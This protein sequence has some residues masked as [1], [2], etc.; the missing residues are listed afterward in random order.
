MAKALDSIIGE[1]KGEPDPWG[2]ERWQRWRAKQEQDDVTKPT[3]NA[4]A[5]ARPSPE[6]GQQESGRTASR[7]NL[8][9]G[10]RIQWP[11]S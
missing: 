10:G 7:E 8:P 1:A 6:R 5:A 9:T 11:E 4:D 3:G 2:K